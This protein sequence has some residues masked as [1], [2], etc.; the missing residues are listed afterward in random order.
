MT[1]PESLIKSPKVSDW[2]DFSIQGVVGIKTGKVEFG[3][4]IRTALTQIVS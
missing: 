1:T 2:L 3:Q 4:G